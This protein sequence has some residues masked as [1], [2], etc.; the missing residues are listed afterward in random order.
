MESALDLAGAVLDQD[1]ARPS[2][3]EQK[4]AATETSLGWDYG[5]KGK[6]FRPKPDQ[7]PVSGAQLC[8]QHQVSVLH[9]PA[10]EAKTLHWVRTSKLFIQ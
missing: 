8:V 3:P 10:Q 6:D 2:F 9:P 7:V 4:A 5:I 1:S